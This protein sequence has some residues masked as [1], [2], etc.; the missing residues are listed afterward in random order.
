M[1][2]LFLIGALGTLCFAAPAKHKPAKP[3]TKSSIAKPKTSTKATAAKGAEA[4]SALVQSD[5]ICRRD[6]A[7]GKLDAVRSR[8]ADLSPANTAIATY[9]RMTLSDDP[10]DLRKGFAPAVL[11]KSELDSR[12]LLAAG[13]YHF[14]RGQ[15]REMEDLVEIARK[16]K[17]KGAELD[18]LKLLAAGK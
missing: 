1:R 16:A 12:L 3:A 18:T 8:C 4:N 17:L 9:W 10:N 11:A 5:K 7:W 14:A 6:Q 15:I 2:W 13:R